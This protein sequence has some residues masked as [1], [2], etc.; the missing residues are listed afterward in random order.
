MDVCRNICVNRE[1]LGGTCPLLVSVGTF[2][3]G[4]C[5]IDH[6]PVVFR[7]FAQQMGSVGAVRV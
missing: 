4:S 1:R 3:S 6:F 2:I 5:N 7:S